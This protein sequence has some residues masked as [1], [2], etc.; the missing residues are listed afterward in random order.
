MQCVYFQFEE[1]LNFVR[2][3]KMYVNSTDFHDIFVNE[4]PKYLLV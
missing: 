1:T 3:F 2:E 4:L